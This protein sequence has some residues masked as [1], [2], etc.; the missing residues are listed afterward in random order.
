MSSRDYLLLETDHFRIEHSI[1]YRIAGFLFVVPKVVTPS[2]SEMADPAVAELGKALQI[3]VRAVEMV[4]EP[5]NVYCTKFGETDGSV[6]FHIFPRTLGL[7]DM[8]AT[9]QGAIEGIDGPKLM[10]WANNHFTGDTEYGDIPN[11]I[12][13]IRIHFERD[14]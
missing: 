7:T 9:T 3:A 13:E 6:H 5:V 14:A 11:A 8:Y 4:I 2:I 1:Y 12:T 10:S